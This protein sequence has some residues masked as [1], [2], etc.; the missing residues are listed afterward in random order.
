MKLICLKKDL[1]NIL[2]NI[3]PKNLNE[4]CNYKNI[5]VQYLSRRSFTALTSVENSISITV[6]F[7][8]SS[9]IITNTKT[10]KIYFWNN[11]CQPVAKS[12]RTCIKKGKWCNKTIKQLPSEREMYLYWEGTLVS[13]RLLLV[14]DNCIEKAS[15]RD[16]LLPQET[17]R[18]EK[19]NESTA[20]ATKYCRWQRSHKLWMVNE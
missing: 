18:D 4:E 11:L 20:T 5:R 8:R 14:Q 12:S 6:F 19:I 13:S 1:Y 7:F 9:Q 17:L 10:G 16:R 3:I 2:T 15:P